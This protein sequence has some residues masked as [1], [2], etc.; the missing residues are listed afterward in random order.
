M[1]RSRLSVL[2]I[3]AAVAACTTHDASEG[4]ELLSQDRT[5]VAHL[6]LGPESGELPLPSACGTVSVSAQPASA[7]QTQ[8]KKLTLQGQDAEMQGNLQ[9]AR[10][11]LRRAFELDATSKSTAYHLGRTSEALGERT[12]AVTAYCRYLAL[13]PTMTESNEVRQRVTALSQPETHASSGSVSESAAPVRRVS[14][15]TTRRASAGRATFAPRPAR[16]AIVEQEA[17]PTGATTSSSEVRST[18]SGDVVASDEVATSIPEPAVDQPTTVTRTERRGPSQ[19]QGAILGAATGAIIGAATGRSV[20]GAVIGAAAGGILGTV[21]MR[22]TRT[23][24]RGFG[25]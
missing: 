5:L 6:E 7:S 18:S 13:K 12:A 20:K 4:T 25:S 15:T 22:G 8:A 14:T 19:T 9:E 16:R 10:S 11:L 3:F 23:A 24:G 21:I 1:H 2:V 17:R